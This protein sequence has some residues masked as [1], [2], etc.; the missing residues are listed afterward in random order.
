MEDSFKAQDL[1][2]WETQQAKIIPFNC[3]KNLL[4]DA[5]VWQTQVQQD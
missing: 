5:L 4:I 2:L 3:I 1:H